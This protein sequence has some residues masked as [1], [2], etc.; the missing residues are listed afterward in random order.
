MVVVGKQNRISTAFEADGIHHL[1]E[2]TLERLVYGGDA[3]GRLA[4]GRAVFVPFGLPGERVSVR[5][6]E[7]KRDYARAELVEVLKPSPKR[8]RP[9]CTHFTVCGG[10]AYQHLDYAEQLAVKRA[11]LIETLERVGGID[12]PPVEATVPSPLPWYYRNNVQFHLTPDGKLGFQASRSHEVVPIL[13]C[14]VLEEAIAEVWPL[15]EVAAVPELTQIGLRAGAGGEPMLILEGSSRKPPEFSVD[16]PLSAVYHGPDGQFVL[17]GDPFL[18]I[19]LLGRSF[20]VSPGSFFQVN[21]AGAAKMVEHLLASLPL[22]SA[23][24]ILDAYCGVGLF[25]AFLAAQAGRLV[26][27]EVSESAC[28]DFA[29]NLDEFDHVELY[30]GSLEDILPVLDFRPDIVV[31]DPPR[32][33]IAR[34]GLEAILARGPSTIAY[35]S[36]EPPTLARDL[37]WMLAHGYHLEKVT[38]FDL[39]P[40]TY[41]IESISILRRG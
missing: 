25:S 14:H 15:I 4:N 22:D 5:L 35:V 12:H 37:R 23:P 10:C 38:P 16:F 41:H 17:A 33:G 29:A 13:E 20:R 30:Q 31:A 21:T 8:I 7:E 1:A 39:F 36:C 34:R 24:A 40:Q 9:R 2:V 26:G 6:V 27:V 28:Q 18:T 32:S 3:V 19:E 11:L